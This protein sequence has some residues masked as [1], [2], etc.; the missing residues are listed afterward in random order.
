MYLYSK[1]TL[2]HL[3][4]Y[5]EVI[6]LEDVGVIFLSFCGICILTSIVAGLIHISINNEEEYRLP[7]IL[8]S[9]YCNLCSR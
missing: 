3:G 4:I 5:P 7:H 9:I 2:L 8:A 6:W 1:L